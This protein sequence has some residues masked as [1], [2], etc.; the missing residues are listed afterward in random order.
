MLRTP[1]ENRWSRGTPDRTEARRGVDDPRYPP[2]AP[3][4]RPPGAHHSAARDLD[5]PQSGGSCGCAKPPSSP[6]NLPRCRAS[7]HSR[8]A[9]C[10]AGGMCSPRIRGA[11]TP[12]ASRGVTPRRRPAT[13]PPRT[14]GAPPGRGTH[15]GVTQRPFPGVAPQPGASAPHPLTLRTPSG[16]REVAS[17][18]AALG[19]RSRLANPTRSAHPGSR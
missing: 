4:W 19:Q 12:Y 17:G 15:G 13:A 2:M 7:S 9:G 6:G 14:G 8:A 10:D 1:T 5:E 11:D 18:H 3:L 16:V